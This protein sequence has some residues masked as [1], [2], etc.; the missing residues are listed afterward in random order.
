VSART[1]PTG[2]SLVV[3]W[4][5]VLG[6][7]CVIWFVPFLGLTPQQRHLLAIFVATIVALVSHPVLF[8]NVHGLPLALAFPLI[9]LAYLYAHYGF[10]SMTAQVTALYPSFLAAAL[11]TGVSPLVAALAL[12]YFSNLDAA[13]THYGTGS[14]P[15][16]FGAGYVS[17]GKWW[18]VGFLVS[19]LNVVIWLG[20][21]SLWWKILGW[22]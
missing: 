3:R 13:L 15:I 1:Q 2:R 11:L 5:L 8:A 22:W 10:A 4:V 14:A 21:G 7:G 20:V 6:V 19:L 18:R 17:Q 16:F 12:A 9:A